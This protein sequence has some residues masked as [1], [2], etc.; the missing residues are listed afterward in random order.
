MVVP[1]APSPASRMALLTWALATGTR[2]SIAWSE[3]P[4]MT[5]GA[6]PPVEVDARA[7]GGER[8]DHAL[9][10]PP[11]ER[12]VADERRLNGMAGD[13]PRQQPQRRARVGRVERRG[14]LAEAVGAA[15]GD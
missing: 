11:A 10:G 1:R 5:S 12:F 8:I 7:H 4:S 2:Q 14:G 3:P 9:H 6:R 13:E 15:T